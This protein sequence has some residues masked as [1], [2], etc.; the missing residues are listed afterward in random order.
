MVFAAVVSAVVHRPLLRIDRSAYRRIDHLVGLA[1]AS[2]TFGGRGAWWQPAAHRS[3]TPEGGCA[4]ASSRLAAACAGLR[5]GIGR[6]LWLATCLASRKTSNDGRRRQDPLHAEPHLSACG[7]TIDNAVDHGQV[8]LARRPRVTSFV[9]V[10]AVVLLAVGQPSEAGASESGEREP[11][12]TQHS[13]RGNSAPITPG[14]V[15][16]ARRECLR[17][18]GLRDVRDNDKLRPAINKICRDLA[19]MSQPAEETP[20][21]WWRTP[22]LAA[23]VAAVGVAIQ[24]YWLWLSVRRPPP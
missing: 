24:A 3:R 15:A 5:A 23:A 11:A 20:S 12:S 9:W 10:L 21:P 14:G 1:S 16:H 6:I 22:W 8:P 13:Q 4:T 19:A 7:V 18:F 2:H 17:T